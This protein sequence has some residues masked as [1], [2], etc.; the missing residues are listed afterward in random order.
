MADLLVLDATIEGALEHIV[1]ASDGM[2][3]RNAAR[4]VGGFESLS[5]I[6]GEVDLFLRGLQVGRAA[7]ADAARTAGRG[8]S[9]MMQE[10][11][12]LDGSLAASLG[13]GF[14]V[15]GSDS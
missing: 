8:L 15:R 2:S 12:D 11:A 13:A 6:A 3:D 10:T 9:A 7:L 4:P 5:G 14:A 1:M